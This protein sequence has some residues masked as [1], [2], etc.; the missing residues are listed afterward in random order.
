M[1]TYHIKNHVYMCLVSKVLNNP[2]PACAARVTVLGLCVSVCLTPDTVSFYVE[3]KIPVALVQHRVDFYKK[4]FSYKCFVR[5]LWRHLLTYGSTAATFHA[6]F[7]R[8]SSKGPKMVNNGL[9]TSWKTKTVSSFLNS[10]CLL[11]KGLPYTSR[12]M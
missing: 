7:R 10:L 3:M 11:H 4:R 1:V 8:Q 2:W 5:K 9:N 12:Y 6:L